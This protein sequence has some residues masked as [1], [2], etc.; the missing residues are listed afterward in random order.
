MA[1][2][3]QTPPPTDLTD[4]MLYETGDP[5]ALY[6]RLRR[7]APVWRQR[8]TDGNTFHAVLRHRDILTAYT[9]TATFS[10]VNGIR[11]GA[12]TTAV[13]Y[14]AHKMLIVSDP[15]VHA[16]LRRAISRTL[17]PEVLRSLA[18][19]LDRHIGQLFEQALCADAVDLVHDIARPISQTVICDL[20][21]VPP[22]DRAHLVDL[23][24][25]AFEAGE[26]NTRRAANTEIFL[27]FDDLLDQHRSRPPE[28]GRPTVMSLLA[29]SELDHDTAVLN[30]SGLLSGGNE[31]TRHVLSAGTL[32]LARHPGQF[33]RLTTDAALTDPAVEELLRYTSPAVY[34]LRTV[35]RPVTLAGTHFAKGDRV[36]LWNASG[37][38]DE[39]V[40]PDPDHLLLD[41]TPNRHLGFG[42][43]RH[44]CIGARFARLEIA[45][46]LGHLRTRVRA[47]QVA[48]PP[49]WNGSN[50]ARGLTSLPIRLVPR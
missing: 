9:D 27:Y 32:A 34:V 48:G 24:T 14:A 11:I 16:H 13:D 8:D 29:H 50:F 6:A 43:G 3:T 2:P 7:Q 10:S 23:T 45:T 4:R 33:A 46:Y 19:R 47:L 20:L 26:E 37:N 36:A 1:D 17:T 30:C 15:P 38:R 31:T 21:G 22:T 49:R 40:F 25:Q 39:D 12:D 44:I 28:S 35:T 41:R 42:Q 5:E 18:A